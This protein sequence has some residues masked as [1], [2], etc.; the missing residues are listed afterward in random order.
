MDNDT[1]YV[2][3]DDDEMVELE[4]GGDDDGGQPEPNP[5]T[6]QQDDQGNYKKAMHSERARRK[7]AEERATMYEAM[8]K[9]FSMERGADKPKV[10]ADPIDAAIEKYSGDE[11]MAPIVEAM[12]F[13]RNNQAKP[14]DDVIGIK[15]D[16]LAEK[17]PGANEHR[18][19]V[20]RAAKEYGID[21]KK[22]Y[23]ML[24]GEEAMN[25][26]A[27]DIRRQMELQSAAQPSET[28]QI[29]SAGNAQPTPQKTKKTIQVSRSEAE[30]M[31]RMGITPAQYDQFISAY[32]NSIVNAQRTGMRPGVQASTMNQIFGG[33]GSAK[34]G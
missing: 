14:T 9:Q 12:K 8:L 6:N 17:Y 7:E 24:Y 29:N 25:A 11:A 21:V 2:V 34:K 10:V 33:K 31:K 28:A 23:F 3:P 30:R 22:A 1:Q 18:S 19:D 15:F 32:T 13:L 27:D 5:E 20:I 4:I 26:P 16:A